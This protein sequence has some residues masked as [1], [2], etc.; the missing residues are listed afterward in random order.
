MI[1][2]ELHELI[3][4][5]H[6]NELN[7]FLNDRIINKT[8]ECVVI[9]CFAMNKLRERERESREGNKGSEQKQFDRT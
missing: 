8:V 4:S 2:F 5:Q 1:P 9:F 6:N 3:E 7:W